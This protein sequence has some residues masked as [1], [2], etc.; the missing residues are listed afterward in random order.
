MKSIDRRT[1]LKSVPAVAAVGS[2]RLQPAS[3]TPF[4]AEYPYLDSQATGQW[5]LAARGEA[6]APVQGPGTAP[7]KVPPILDLNVPRNQV[8]V[9]AL[10]T[11]DAGI[12]TL[13]AQLYPLLPDE[14]REA[15]LEIQR[16]GAWKMIASHSSRVA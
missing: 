4:G 3:S 5:W 8:V 16:D 15:R 11:H 1:F 6:A 2:I 14:P 7:K 12:L 13:S 10:Y 9:F